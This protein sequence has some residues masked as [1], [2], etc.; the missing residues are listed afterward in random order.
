MVHNLADQWRLKEDIF[1]ILAKALSSISER[2]LVC[3]D[4]NGRVGVDVDGVH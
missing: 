4:L 1:T 2:L 3:G